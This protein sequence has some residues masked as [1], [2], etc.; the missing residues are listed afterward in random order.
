[1]QQGTPTK[2]YLLGPMMKFIPLQN[3]VLSPIDPLLMVTCH[4]DIGS[5]YTHDPVITS[6]SP[7]I[8]NFYLDKLSIDDAITLMS[9]TSMHMNQED[10]GPNKTMHINRIKYGLWCMLYT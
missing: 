7:C 8:S 3:Y 10:I 9:H 1:M 2:N 4:K 5:I 6:V